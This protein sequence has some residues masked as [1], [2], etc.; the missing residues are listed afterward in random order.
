LNA[1]NIKIPSWFS[2]LKILKVMASGMKI[3]LCKIGNFFLSNF[4]VMKLIRK[5]RGVGSDFG[6]SAEPI[7]IKHF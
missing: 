5:L 7:Q 3:I 6:S 4:L 1:E 2:R